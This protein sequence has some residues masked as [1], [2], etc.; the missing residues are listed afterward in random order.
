MIVPASFERELITEMYAEI[1]VSV[2][3]WNYVGTPSEKQLLLE[4]R[5]ILAIDQN[6]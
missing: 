4:L 6:S 2:F 1:F 3:D 5:S